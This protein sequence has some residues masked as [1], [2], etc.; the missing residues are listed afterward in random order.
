MNNL[1]LILL[2]LNQIHNNWKGILKFKYKFIIVFANHIKIKKITLIQFIIV[3]YK[4]VVLF[5][6]N[7][8][9]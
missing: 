9:K 4:L 2:F 3:N 5:L 7:E 8:I 6:K 1:L